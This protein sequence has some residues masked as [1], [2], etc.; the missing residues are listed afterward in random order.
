MF[1]RRNDV[2]HEDGTKP[3]TKIVLKCGYAFFLIWFVLK[4]DPEVKLRRL[5]RQSSHNKDRHS[6]PQL[7]GSNRSLAAQFAGKI[8][9][10]SCA[11]SA[12]HGDGNRDVRGHYNGIG[13][14]TA[15]GIPI[16][17]PPM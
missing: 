2:S 4:S 6:K 9:S 15:I 8:S 1:R 11:D 16:P 12:F 3:L 10:A 5:N 7:V 14:V 17:S 13:E